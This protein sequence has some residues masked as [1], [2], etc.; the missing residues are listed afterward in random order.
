MRDLELKRSRGMLP[1]GQRAK[2]N[3]ARRLD[4]RADRMFRR[5]HMRANPGTQAYNESGGEAGLRHR[6]AAEYLGKRNRRHSSVKKRLAF[7][8][9]WSR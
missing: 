3:L 8:R 9:A 6:F 4:T 2:G 5:A 7:S 1:K